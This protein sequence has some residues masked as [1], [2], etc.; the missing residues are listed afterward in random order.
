[1]FYSEAVSAQ[2]FTVISPRRVPKLQ[3]DTGH[4][5]RM[6]AF[7]PGVS[8]KAE[9]NFQMSPFDKLTD[10]AVQAGLKGASGHNDGSANKL[11]EG[12]EILR[13]QKQGSGKHILAQSL[14]KMW[15]EDKE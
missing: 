14:M 6:N 5:S 8:G 10:T 15:L 12:D 13:E 1:M 3:R 4:D 9:N 2:L 7:A 11:W